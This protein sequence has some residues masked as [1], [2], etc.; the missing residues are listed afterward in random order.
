MPTNN[1]GPWY[2]TASGGGSGAVNNPSLQVAPQSPSGSVTNES[3]TW[4]FN[5]GETST[6]YY[7][8]V[9]INVD[10]SQQGTPS[11]NVAVSL[12]GV[13]SKQLAQ[14]NWYAG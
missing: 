6:Q 11:S 13:D 9:V 2:T 10:A 3:A 4:N 8:D 14:N 5:A 12:A 1:Y 7:L